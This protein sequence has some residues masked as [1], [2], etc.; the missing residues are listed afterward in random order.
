MVGAL[1][2]KPVSAATAPSVGIRF[3]PL[4]PVG[5]MTD[6]AGCAKNLTL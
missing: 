1:P 3:A 5:R 2:A 6:G 4:A